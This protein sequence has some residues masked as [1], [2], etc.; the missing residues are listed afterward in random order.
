MNLD[1]LKEA[2]AEHESHLDRLSRKT[3]VEET[4]LKAIAG[5]S[6]PTLK[7]WRTLSKALKIKSRDLATDPAQSERYAFLYRSPIG[8]KRLNHALLSQLSSK[9]TL[10]DAS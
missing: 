7:E 8:G 9:M 6:E 10:W 4:R 5:G 2:L 3:G 1:L